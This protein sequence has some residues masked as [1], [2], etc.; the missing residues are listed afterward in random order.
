MHPNSGQTEPL[1]RRH[2]TNSLHSLS[3]SP[4]RTFA[5][6]Q[7]ARDYCL[8]CLVRHLGLSLLPLAIHSQKFWGLY[9]PSAFYPTP[10]S[11]GH[12]RTIH[13]LM[14]A[15]QSWWLPVHAGIAVISY[16]FLALAFCGGIMYLIQE[17][18]L[19]NKRFGYFF[20]RLPSLDS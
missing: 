16:G 5:H 9:L 2:I 14:P 12:L 20:T 7:S 1:C 3:L 17:R 6:H 4:G 11:R 8:F 18:E 13:P 10:D 19:K 15:L